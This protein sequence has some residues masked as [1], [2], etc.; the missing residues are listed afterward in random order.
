M[1]STILWLHGSNISHIIYTLKK[2]GL[3]QLNATPHVEVTR[4]NVHDFDIVVEM[5]FDDLYQLWIVASDQM[6]HQQDG[7]NCGPIACLKVLEIYGFIPV[8]SIDDI[9]C[10]KCGYRCIV[11]EHYKKFLVKHENELLLF[12]SKTGMKKL[13][14]VHEDNE[15]NNDNK[16]QQKETD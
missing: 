10:Q 13:G 1:V 15:H 8:N 11:M 14:T 6:L 9:G 16:K 12:L 5:C 4:G 2:Y 3:Q 7:I